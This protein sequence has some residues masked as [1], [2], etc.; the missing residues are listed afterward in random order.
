MKIKTEEDR[1]RLAKEIKGELGI[2]I[3]KYR[4]TEVTETLFELLSFPQY[5]FSYVI[6][7]TLPGK[8]SF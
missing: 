6:R 4:S 7:G 8:K 5:I 2:D 3:E 1:L